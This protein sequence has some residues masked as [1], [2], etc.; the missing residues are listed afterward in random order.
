[1]NHT[2]PGQRI[3]LTVLREGAETQ[4]EVELGERP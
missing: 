3:M 2:R 1:V 4:V